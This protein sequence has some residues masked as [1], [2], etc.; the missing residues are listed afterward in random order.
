M[1]RAGDAISFRTVLKAALSDEPV[2]IF[3]TDYPTPDGT[4]VRDYVHVWDLAQAHEAAMKRLLATQGDQGSFE[5]FNLGSAHGYS[6]REMIAACEKVIGHRLKIVERPRRR[7]RSAP[8]RR[9]PVAR[10]AGTRIPGD[11]Q[12]P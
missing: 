12:R 11:R 5:A 7:G 10:P 2:E 1:A 6:V 3:G 4:A 9:G 8:T